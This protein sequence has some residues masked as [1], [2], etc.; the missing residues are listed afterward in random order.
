MVN[1]IKLSDTIR[2]QLL[3]EQKKDH[4][5]FD[6]LPIEESKT[7]RRFNSYFEMI[8]KLKKKIRIEAMQHLSS[9]SSDINLNKPVKFNPS[10]ISRVILSTC[11]VATSVSLVNGEEM[12]KFYI[13][14]PDTKIMT[15]SEVFIKKII[16]DISSGNN[17]AMEILDIIKA[18]RQVMEKLTY[19]SSVRLL[20]ILPSN[21]VVMKDNT[22]LN[23][24]NN[25]L[26]SIEEI[27]LKYDI[28]NKNAV[29]LVINDVLDLKTRATVEL[30]RQIISRVMKDWSGQDKQVEKLIWEVM[31]SVIRNDNLEKYILIKGSGGNGKST[32]MRLLSNIVGQQATKYVNIHQFG[33]ANAINKLDLSTKVVIGDDAA[34]NFKLNDVAL[35]NM[36]SLMSHQP[37]SVPVKYSEN[38]VLL[39]NAVFIQGTNTDLSLYENNPAVSSRLVII[40]WGEINFRDEKPADITFNLNELIE[41]QLFIDTFVT[42]CLEKIKPFDKYT[43]P[44]VVKKATK[45]M[46]DGS[47]T[48]MQY[49][50]EIKSDIDGYERIPLKLL[51]EH[52]RVYTK[53]YNPSSGVMKYQNFVKSLSEKS[54]KFGYTLSSNKL[55]FTTYHQLTS[56]MNIL[57]VDQFDAKS[58]QTYIAFN[59]PITDNDINEFINRPI[60]EFE[61]LTSRELQML[62]MSIYDKQMSHLQSMFSKHL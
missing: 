46:I 45:D 2:K 26:L 34:T 55:R 61:E 8:S 41:T 50:D 12:R 44:D 29:S 25:E 7:K 51:Y 40:P 21:Y 33:D 23:L 32:Y 58:Q 3:S 37:I 14:N 43:I 59:N 42:M 16:T 10:T 6:R 15:S 54:Q 11:D 35:S 47:D 56:L 48:M 36:K 57:G 52:Y 31:Y 28:V 24:T 4:K 27:E 19:D 39:T 38:V 17:P 49:I 53:T 9:F 1:E 60:N 62:K 20:S 18:T 30:Y 13:Q 22:V 5:S